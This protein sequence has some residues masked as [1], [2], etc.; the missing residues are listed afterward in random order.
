MT[1]FELR[2]IALRYAVQASVVN[3][4]GG[5]TTYAMPDVVVGRAQAYMEFLTGGDSAKQPPKVTKKRR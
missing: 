5:F 4:G 2:E 3:N 1:V